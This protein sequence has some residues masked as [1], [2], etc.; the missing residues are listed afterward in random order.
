M[1]NM[2]H[3]KNIL[4]TG[5]AGFIGSHLCE[6]VI[7]KKPA[8]L[9]V[10]DNLYL[11]KESNLQEAKIAFPKLKFYQVSILQK[12]KL[13]SLMIQHK[14][15]IVFNLAVVPLP[16]SLKYPQITF[17]VN[18]QGT[19]NICELLREGLFKTL[20]H[21]SSSEVYGTARYVPMDEQ[22]PFMPSTPYAASKAGA[23]Q[24]CLSYVKTFDCDIRIVRPFNNYGPR[25]NEKAYA[26]IIPIVIQ[27]V[28]KQRSIEIFGDGE[29]T[30]DFIFVKDT[31]KAIVTVAQHPGMKGQVI[32]IASGK[33]ISVKGLVSVV[34]KALKAENVPVVF[35]EPRPGDVRRHRADTKLAKKLI[36]FRMSTPFK[37]GIKETV[38]WYIKRGRVLK[39]KGR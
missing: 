22:H 3:N 26:G 2:I 18:V 36:A 14:I 32:N 37:D 35:C 15:D 39:V 11:G 20:I 21:C 30:R 13:K 6:E 34:M 8:S 4:I 23:D 33:E 17:R 27:R 16:A 5:G 38:E 28:M 25:Q 9:I 10:V 31:V 19:Q 24:L 12:A 29:Q 7:R 1:M